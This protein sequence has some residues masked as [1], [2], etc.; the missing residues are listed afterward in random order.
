MWHS[1]LSSKNNTGAIF[2]YC[3]G[4]IYSYVFIFSVSRENSQGANDVIALN[5]ISHK[6][7][8]FL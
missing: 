6:H 1:S 3:F 4:F 5:R 7:G 2:Q 8:K